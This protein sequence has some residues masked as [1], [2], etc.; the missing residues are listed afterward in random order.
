MKNRLTTATI[1]RFS[2]RRPWYVLATW[3]ILL[4]LAGVAS[5]GLGDAF[6]TES[7]FTNNP[8]SV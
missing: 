2:A 6:T 4:I 5:T 8:E 1:A 3:L 7:D